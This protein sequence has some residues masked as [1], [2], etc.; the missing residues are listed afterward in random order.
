MA[1]DIDVCGCWSSSWPAS[2]S[3]S[4][5]FFASS[6]AAA[7]AAAAFFF[8]FFFLLFFLFFFLLPGSLFE[9]AAPVSSDW[10]WE[11]VPSRIKSLGDELSYL[12]SI[13]N[14]WALLGELVEP[15][16]EEGSGS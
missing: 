2:S 12:S 4:S 13:N 9:V 11:A 6:A 15:P 8:L 14:N 16:E 7:C 10:S 5:S 3:S 1:A